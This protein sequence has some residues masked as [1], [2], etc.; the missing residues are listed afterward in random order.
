[1]N[2]HY[3][4]YQC[5]RRYGFKGVDARYNISRLVVRIVSNHSCSPGTSFKP[6][7]HLPIQQYGWLN[8]N[9]WIARLERL[10]WIDL[11]DGRYRRELETCRNRRTRD[12]Y[13]RVSSDGLVKLASQLSSQTR[14]SAVRA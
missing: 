1:M 9:L 11:V 5:L 10:W 13:T 2:S 4:G 14:R 6:K 8:L 3:L 7:C 12:P